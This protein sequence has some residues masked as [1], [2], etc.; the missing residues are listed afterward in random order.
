[1]CILSPPET[2]Q[3][4]LAYIQP[5]SELNLK[6]GL[7]IV[8]ST[9]H[10]NPHFGLFCSWVFSAED[11]EQFHRQAPRIENKISGNFQNK[12]FICKCAVST[13]EYLG[14]ETGI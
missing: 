2:Q 1:M 5:Q 13:F 4:T 6:N 7:W 12:T 11:T 10:T 8:A 14:G 9:G 3:L